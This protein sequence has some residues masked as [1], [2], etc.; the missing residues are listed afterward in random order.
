MRILLLADIHGNMPALQ[1][2]DSFFVDSAFDAIV[3]CGDSV[4][5][6]PFP[7]QVLQWLQ[8]RNVVSILGNTDKK[9]IKLLKGKDFAK[10]SDPEKRVM[11]TH[12]ARQL[13]ATNGALLS[14]LPRETSLPLSREG[15]DTTDLGKMLGIFHGSPARPHEFLFDTTPRQRF[16]DLAA[17]YPYRAI[18]TG[19]SH[20]PYHLQVGRTHFINPGSVGRM[21]DGNPAA[22]CAVLECDDDR[23]A[24]HHHR[25]DYDVRQ[26][27]DEIGRQGL[28][29]IY[30]E[31]FRQGS[32]LN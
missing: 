32:K 23:F 3:N 31:M 12:T 25:I 6:A 8:S 13:T 18:V 28:P 9:I 30:Q 24:V 11:Y 21:F 4:V 27:I 1:A 26:V 5:Y 17:E 15:S 16:I 22:C 10:P 19:H 14:N 2:V 20:T 7:N 29:A